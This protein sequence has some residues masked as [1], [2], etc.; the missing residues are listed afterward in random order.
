MKKVAATLVVQSI[1]S[2]FFCYGQ[3]QDNIWYFGDSAGL[4]FNSGIPI[5]L[6]DGLSSSNEI[7]SA[8]SDTNGNLLFYVGAKTS[9]SSNGA[10]MYL[11]IWNR[12]QQ[13]MQNGDTLYGNYSVT[14]GCIIVPFPGDSLHYYIFHLEHYPINSYLY[15][16]IVDMTLDSGRGG[17]IS[18]N[19]VLLQD[20]LTEKMQAVK[21][22]NG[23]DWWLLVHDGLN[24]EFLEF[25]IDPNGFH[26][27]YTYNIGSSG[28]GIGQLIFSKNGS[29]L[30]YTRNHSV[31]LFDFDRC[32]GILSNWTSLGDNNFYGCSFS[33]NDSVLY[34]SDFDTLYQFDLSATNIQASQQIIWY[35]PNQSVNG[36]YQHKLASNG[37][38]YIANVYNLSFPN[39]SYD[40]TNEYICVIDNP[41][42][43]GAAC[44]FA[45]YSVYLGGRRSFAGLPNNPNYNL[46]AWANSICDTIHVGIET[47][48]EKESISVFPNP[49]DGSFMISYRLPNVN[50]EFLIKDVTGRTVY[51]LIISG[52]EGTKNVELSTL[53]NG[54]CYWQLI[55]NFSVSATGK[56][57]IIK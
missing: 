45:P 48:K 14:Q 28:G 18:K 19:N 22:G 17:I 6:L 10:D 7:T 15:Y 50:G 47:I 3:R 52:T 39:Q 8:I 4:N 27:P 9:A 31:D 20:T 32:T 49:N 42:S 41:D 53:N 2:L 35:V 11:T 38:I 5:P 46:G 29:R 57:A 21:H 37:K 24:N 55:S 23:R 16:S 43:L 40:S 25:L 13:I 33:P 54:I 36:I 12:N 51:S 30:C 34:A 56:L 44:N 26:G 1:F